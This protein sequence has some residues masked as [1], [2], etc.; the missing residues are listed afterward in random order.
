M[1]NYRGLRKGIL[2]YYVF[3]LLYLDGYDLR[4]LPL[5]PRKEVLTSIIK[6]LPNVKVSEHIAEHG[7]AFFDAM[8]TVLTISFS[9]PN[10]FPPDRRIDFAADAS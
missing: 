1:Q 10:T 3:D 6:N 9:I 7:T 5:L 8:L 4:T 2:A